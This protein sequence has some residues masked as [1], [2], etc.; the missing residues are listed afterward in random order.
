M[1]L[2]LLKYTERNYTIT[3]ITPPDLTGVIEVQYGHGGVFAFIRFFLLTENSET[4]MFI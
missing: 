2:R 4:L 3:E 1:I